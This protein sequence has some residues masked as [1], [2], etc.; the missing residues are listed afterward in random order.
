MSSGLLA[1]LDDVSAL[2]KAASVSL[3]D[4]PAQVAKTSYKVSG[5]VIDDAAVT[6]KYVVGLDPSRELAIIYRI[7][8]SS[9]INKLFILGPVILSLG[10]FAPWI[11]TPLLMLGGC[12]LCYEG[13]EKVHD[14]CFGAKHSESENT[15]IPQ[16]SPE[17]LEK[18][19]VNSAV[20][21]DFI[22]SA[23]IIAITY[24][25]VAS[26]PP[27]N[28]I[29]VIT[30]VAILITLLVYGSVAILVKMD[31][32]GLYLANS[33]SI[34]VVKGFGRNLVKAMPYVLSL[35]SYVGTVAML[36]V[37]AE[38]IAHGVPFLHHA[39]TDL[40]NS[41]AEKPWTL[42]LVKSSCLVLGGVVFGGFLEKLIAALKK[43]RGV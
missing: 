20:R 24:S 43:I 32:F 17:E 42:F 2:F 12:F 40:Q 16:I 21:T 22:L 15:E 3:D 19:R 39:L 30:C 38:I 14:I 34:A 25:T 7:A 41:L 11:I 37:G 6:P 8:K 9:L 10:Y 27:F 28:Q 5:I 23:E 35:L 26:N 18:L 31:D 4:V 36:L 13:Y 1:L 33:D 29:A